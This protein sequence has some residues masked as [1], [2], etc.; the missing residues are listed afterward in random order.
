MLTMT[1][2]LHRPSALHPF[3]SLGFRP[4][5][6]LAAVAAGVLLPLWGYYFAG[7]LGVPTRLAPPV[8]HGHEMLF[9]FTAAVIAGFL[10]TAVPNWTGIPAVRGGRLV[11]LAAL[12]IAGRLAVYFGT[13]LPA[14][15]VAAI[16]V[17]FFPAL[18]LA[19][20]PAL[21]ASDNRRNF[22]FPI[23]LLVFALANLAIHAAAMGYLPVIGAEIGIKVAVGLVT[24]LMIVIG[25]RV[26]PGFTANALGTPSRRPNWTDKGA[27]YA[28]IAVLLL[29]LLP[30]ARPAQGLAAAAA[31]VLVALRMRGWQSLRT[32]RQPILWVLHLGYAWIAVGFA[33]KALALLTEMLRWQDALHGLT[34][35]AIGTLTLGMMSRVALGHTGRPLRVRPSITA[36]YILI[37]LATVIR[38]CTPFAAA[39]HPVQALTHVAGALWAAAFIIY[40]VV[41]APML[42]A[43]RA[44][45]RP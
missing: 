39:L 13:L 26:I 37:T 18:V 35:G 32:A 3:W 21:V 44:D 41:Y 38:L 1:D 25:G 43:P 40:F 7:D 20:A 45:G 2:A 22:G 23:V 10:L 24:L 31:A 29:E 30:Q 15:L 9:G 17:A 28:A 12:W 42:V 27:L 36:A 5:F 4:F 33:F 16:D 34:A 11:A 8:W 14:W 19:I 6:L